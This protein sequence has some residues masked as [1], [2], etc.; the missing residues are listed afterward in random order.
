[1]YVCR[2]SERAVQMRTNAEQT[3]GTTFRKYSL[4][5]SDLYY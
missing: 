1:M 4:Q 5:L 2:L 3:E